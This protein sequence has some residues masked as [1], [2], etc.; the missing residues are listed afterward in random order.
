VLI[1]GGS[2]GQSA[3]DTV[4]VY[5]PKVQA[6]YPAGRMSVPRQGLSATV[7]LD[8]RVFLAGG[9]NGTAD[10]ASAEIFDPK[11]G[12]IALAGSMV[13]ARQGHLSF[14]LPDN[15]EIL[16]VGGTQNDKPLDAAEV[17]IPWTGAFKPINALSMPRSGAAGAPLQQKGSLLVAGGLSAKAV[18]ATAEAFAFNTITTDRSVYLPGQTVMIAGSRWSPGE[19]VQIVR[20][21]VSK[22]DLTLTAVADSSG[23]IVNGQLQLD[24]GDIGVSTLT[25]KGEQSGSGAQGT[26]TTTQTA[27]SVSY[28]PGTPTTAVPLGQVETVTGTVIALGNPAPAN[29][30]CGTLDFYYGPNA[31]TTTGGTL[32]G[33]VDLGTLMPSSNST[34]QQINTSTLGVGTFFFVVVYDPSTCV[35]NPN[36]YQ[37]SITDGKR[38]NVSSLTLTKT[39]SPTTYSAVGQTI[40]YTYVITNNGNVPLGPAQFTISDDHINGN[41]PF[42]CGPNNTTLPPNG[43]VSCTAP[44][45]ITQ[46]DLDAGSVTNTAT[47]SGAGFTSDKATATVTG[48]QTKTI[49]LAK[50]ANPATYAVGTTI[51]YTYVVKNTGNTTLSGPFTISDN[52]LGT[53]SCPTGSLAPGATVTCTTTYTTTQTDVDNV[54]ITNI[55]TASGSGLTS[56]Q[57]TATVTAPDQS[58]SISL[59]KSANPTTYAVG[60]QITYTYVVKNTGKVTLS[61]PFTI[62]DNKLGTISCPAGPLAPGATVTCTTTYTTTQ[63]DVDNGSITNIATASGNGLTSNQDTATVTAPDQTKSISLTKSANP[64]TYVVGTTIT[65]TYVVKNTGKVTLSGPFTI[66]D[67]KL[68]TISCP[69]GSLAPGATVTCTTT[70]TTTQTDVDNVSITNIAT[71]SGN[72][73]TSNQDTA[74]VTAPDQSKSISLTKSANPTTYAVGTQITYTYVVKNTGKVTLSG[75]FTISDNK[76]GTVSCPTGPLAPGATVTC[77]TTYTATQADVDGGSITNVATA[78]GN[79][80]TSNQATATVTAPDQS[81]SIG[82]TKSANPTTYSTVGTVITYTYVVKNTGKVTL[83]GPFSISDNKLGTISPC[84]TGPLAPGAS[85]SCTATHTIT[86]ADLTAGSIVNIATASGNGV[87]SNQATATVTAIIVTGGPITTYT[88][89][90]WGSEPHGGNPGALLAANFAKVYPNG[91]T[92]GGGFTLTFTKASAVAA[93]LPQGGTPGALTKSAIDPTSS[94]ANVFGG[95]VLALE[96]SVDFS[97]KGITASGLGGLHLTSGPLAGQTVAQVLAEANQAIGGGALPPGMSISNLNDVVDKINNA[98]DNGVSNGYVK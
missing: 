49:S 41:A 83:S 68:G 6:I 32:F 46:G 9:N 69:A 42:S 20:H 73:L 60:T 78:S 15:N 33:S 72:G 66:S 70:Y 44:Y 90:G 92:I 7:M 80:L 86:Q 89:G 65:Y 93:F 3:L 96:L 1:A 13:S 12:T 43:T 82:L 97:G 51:T 54:S 61:G 55:A 48:T 79:G 94:S 37:T 71:A 22:P 56:N 77:T 11:T 85:T 63:T 27:T 81:K 39:A 5:D 25:A 35:S 75:P 91:V 67:N 26:L 62:G 36:G 87:T 2:D 29:P 28:T 16:L 58:K 88:Q 24:A 98:F 31:G 8:G 17:Y 38:I 84:G 47:A 14:R 52:K 53:I 57:D 18:T 21:G 4:D 64:A 50:S 30:T 10:L 34:T 40:T 95:Q 76:L 74:T 59:T 45:Q 23:N 19:T